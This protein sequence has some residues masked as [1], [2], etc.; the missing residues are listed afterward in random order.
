MPIRRINS[1]SKKLQR[2]IY[3][4]IYITGGGKSMSHD[5]VEEPMQHHQAYNYSKTRSSYR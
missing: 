3:I 5:I 1:K 2:G 4:Y